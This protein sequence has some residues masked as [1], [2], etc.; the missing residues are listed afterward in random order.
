[1]PSVGEA[2]LAKGKIEIVALVIR[3]EKFSKQAGCG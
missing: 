1:M 2:Y 3:R